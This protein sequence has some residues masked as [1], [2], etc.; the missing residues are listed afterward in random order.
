MFQRQLSP[1]K[2]QSFFLFGARGTGKTTFVRNEFLKS[3]NIHYIDLLDPESEDRYRLDPNL[4]A[5]ELSARAKKPDWIVI[6]EVQRAP[7]MLDLVHLLIEKNHLKFILTGSSS[8]KLGHGASNLLAGRAFVNHLFPLTSQEIGKRFDLD[9]AL[10]YGTLPKLFALKS[11]AERLE[12]LKSYALV[13]LNEEIR[14]EQ[15]VRKL[16]PFRSFLPVAAQ[17][18][19][20]KINASKIAREVGVDYKTVENYFMILAET[21]MGF[22]LPAF[23]LSV[24]KAQLSAPK[25]YLF[26][27][28]VKRTLD[29]TIRSPL[30]ESTSAFGECFE[31]FLILELYRLNSY[32]R[33]DFD[34]SYFETAN[35]A[36][37]DLILSRG[38]HR[39]ALEL[40]STTKVD[41]KEAR[42]LQRI[43]KDIPGIRGIYYVSRDPR[44]QRIDDVSCIHW[45]DFVAK[46]DTL[47]KSG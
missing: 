22:H 21:W 23:H 17:M 25:F 35:G 27:I 28:G 10:T 8:R 15:L 39:F 13:Y 19:G 2:T 30:V 33:L 43:A 9:F 31:H 6:D 11:E 24:R 34:F 44:K 41:E 1:L 18:N 4:L 14:A 46:L 47:L 29:K 5:R 26:D 36:E 16:D 42:S 38:K 3:G 12:F 40:K 37:I 45:A 7:R 32:L 20:K